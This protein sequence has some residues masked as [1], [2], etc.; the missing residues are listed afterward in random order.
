MNCLWNTLFV[1]AVGSASAASAQ[2]NA[3]TTVAGQTYG[4]YWPAKIG[5]DSD[6]NDNGP[7]ISITL[8]LEHRANASQIW[9]HVYAHWIENIWNWSEAELVKSFR[10]ATAPAGKAYTHVWIGNQW[11]PLGGPVISSVD[12]SFTDQSWA[13][14]TRSNPDFWISSISV[15]GDT[16]GPDIGATTSD[17]SYLKFVLPTLYF[18]HN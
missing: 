15:L 11:V 3:W 7:D 8:S 10:I 2:A 17:D 12:W 14:D 18:H 5:G 9:V 16:H 1:V 4:P 6:F 13:L